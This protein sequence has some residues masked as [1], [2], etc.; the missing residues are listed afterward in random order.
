MRRST[1]SG[2]GRWVPTRSEKPQ[3][4]ARLR[5]ELRA[6]DETPFLPETGAPGSPSAA[7]AMTSAVK[8]AVESARRRAEAVDSA[9][10]S[11][12]QA[13][14]GV[15]GVA[16]V[17]VGGYGH[18]ELA[19]GSD[20]DVLVVHEGRSLETV[21]RVLRTILYPLWDAGFTVG[22]AARTPAECAVE[23]SRRLETLTS[24]FDA[25]LLAGSEGLCLAAKEAALSVSRND[26]ARV[27]DRLA[28]SRQVRLARFG[29]L[30]HQLEPDLKESIG[31]LRDVR[32]AEWVATLR[33]EG[34]PSGEGALLMAARVALQR[35][36]GSSANRLF[37]EHQEP[38]ARLLGFEDAD[39]REARDRL[40][41]DLYSEA[42]SVHETIGGSL[43]AGSARPKALRLG[44]W[45]DLVRLLAGGPDE[46]HVVDSSIGSRALIELV[47][48][49]DEVLGRPQRDP[50]HRYPVDVHL[51]QTAG[52]AL[53]LLR[54]PDEAFAVEA[55]ALVEDP[56]PLLLGALLH[57][58][59]KVGSPSHVEAGTLRAGRALKRLDV[60]ASV[61]DD[62]LFLVEEHLL[63]ADTATRRNLDDQELIDHVAARVRDERR[64]AMLYL[65]TVADSTATGPA[66]ST[67]WRMSLV[68][69]LVARVSGTLGRGGFTRDQA[70]RLRQAESAVREALSGIPG[71]EIEEF[72]LSVPPSYLLG[73]RPED[74]RRH[75]SLLSGPLDPD[76]VRVDVSAGPT[77]GT[78]TVAVAARDRLGLLARI[79]GSFAVAGLSIL[80]AQAFTT[81]RGTAL[82]VFQV[83]GA[84][85]PTITPD[86]WQRF[87]ATLRAALS[88]ETDLTERVRTLR[89]QYRRPRGG[90][91]VS[92]RVDEAASGSFS[93]VEVGCTDR[94]GLLFDLAQAFSS[95]EVDVHVAKVATYGARVV[96]VFY[97][98]DRTGQKLVGAGR[99]TELEATL[100]RAASGP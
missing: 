27:M 43:A 11:L 41:R 88:E 71:H 42:R 91:R 19:P 53:H 79:A 74:A 14:P 98:T 56:A 1:G 97:V 29:L 17:A 89:A 66:A 39:R 94:L 87:E 84:F 16:I 2:P 62:V 21:E 6:L 72:L 61:R 70:L 69:D 15:S 59:G 64:L 85:E 96:D 52:H 76:E 93:V 9:I 99:L 10:R 95:I 46:L 3:A 73:V 25:R 4:I 86:R 90:P 60:D 100:T 32:L 28:A 37:A 68:R 8:A 31:G 33:S 34:V 20:V 36:S 65:L 48:E 63:L 5:A 7:G 80:S 83:Q 44:S 47:P 50:Y 18:G 82:D 23:S 13:A 38:V 51:L 24:F 26:R 55:A 58:I 54:E 57:D 78:S 40:M 81:E 45:K 75:L 35:S 12:F 77:S 49:W 22:H 92:V 67:A 30:H